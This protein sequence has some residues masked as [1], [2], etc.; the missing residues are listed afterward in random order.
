MSDQFESAYALLV[1]SEEKGRSVLETVLYVAFILSAVLSI[2]QFAQQPMKVPAAGL[3]PA[4]CVAC[5]VN[6]E[7]PGGVSGGTR[8]GVNGGIPSDVSEGED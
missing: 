4:R 3:Q 1:R 8:S 6:G 5:I 2:W 7:V